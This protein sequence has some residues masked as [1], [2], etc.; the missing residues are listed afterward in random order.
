MERERYLRRIREKRGVIVGPIDGD[1]IEVKCRKSHHFSLEIG[2][3]DKWCPFCPSNCSKG[4][5]AIEQ[6]LVS[7]GIN[8]RCEFPIDIDKKRYYFDF[9]IKQKRLLIEFDG[10]QHFYSGYFG[11]FEEVRKNDLRKNKW[12]LKNK[13]H[14]LRIKFD[15]FEQI[16]EI[17]SETLEM[18]D[19]LKEG[20]F[21]TT[22]EDYYY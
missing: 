6:Y 21:L 5:L 13:Y 8:Y 15:E 14:L 10:E 9:L 11:N 22:A 2:V 16:P 20:E 7:K 1:I 17:L 19:N 4:E 3:L 18:I 12:S